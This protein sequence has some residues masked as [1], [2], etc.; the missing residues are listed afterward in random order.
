M[1]PDL[2]EMLERLME[3]KGRDEAWKDRQTQPGSD[4]ISEEEHYA[5]LITFGYCPFCNE[6]EV[7]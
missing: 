2:A 1:T 7:V 4:D 6:N 5:S 3:Q